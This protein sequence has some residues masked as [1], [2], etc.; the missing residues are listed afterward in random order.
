M[1]IS[2]HPTGNLPS[3][4][5]VLL[6]LP[7]QERV[8]HS[9]NYCFLICDYLRLNQQYDLAWQVK[10]AGLLPRLP[11]ESFRAT[12][13]ELNAGDDLPLTITGAIMFVTVL[14]LASKAFV[15]NVMDEMRSYFE[16]AYGMQEEQFSDFRRYFLRLASELAGAVREHLG[17][18]TSFSSAMQKLDA[19][20]FDTD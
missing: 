20:T 8:L 7:M 3:A 15:S 10:Q 9:L 1:A 14:D 16:G 2:E 5:P 6:Y 18:E 11:Y 17:A 12:V 4:A 13:K 19:L